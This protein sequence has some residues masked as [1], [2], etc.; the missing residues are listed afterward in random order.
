[1]KLELLEVLIFEVAGLRHALRADQVQELLPAQAIM[2]VPGAAPGIEGV[3]N[4]RGAIVPV[5]DAR[6]RFGLPAGPLSV[7]HHFIVV[8]GAGRV[9]ALH[10]DRALELARLEVGAPALIEASKPGGAGAAQV[11]TLG[12]GMVVLHE[13]ASLLAGANLLPWIGLPAAQ[14][15]AGEVAPL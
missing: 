7:A 3:I 9:F 10:V 11:A 4:L 6:Q 1:M 13:A 2:P 14:G 12:Q 8:R 5:L 15:R